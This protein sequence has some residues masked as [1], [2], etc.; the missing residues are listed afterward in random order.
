MTA[1]VALLRGINV[2]GHRKV[3]MAELR[4]V[5]TDLGFEAVAT[6]VQSGNLVFSANGG[7]HEVRSRLEAAI[8]EHFGF[9]VDV[10]LRSRDE[11]TSIAAGHPLD[12]PGRDP[13]FLHVVVLRDEPAAAR[14][15]TLAPE[16]VV[17][18]EVELRGREVYVFYPNGSGRSRLVIDLG[19]PGTARNWR[20]VLA[21]RDLLEAIE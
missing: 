15:E 7:P 13:R 10:A 2:G 12:A 14:L 9:E 16:R 17:P 20:T 5:A 1:Y 18:E 11:W 19:T 3:P 6:Y 4:G 21:L 8:A